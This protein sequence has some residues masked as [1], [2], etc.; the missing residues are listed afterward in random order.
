M[1]AIRKEIKVQ[2]RNKTIPQL[3]IKFL[4]PAKSAKYDLLRAPGLQNTGGGVGVKYARV[5]EASEYHLCQRITDIDEIEP[6]DI[7]FADWLWFVGDKDQSKT[8]KIKSFI[9]LPNVKGIY[10]SECSVLTWE[11]KEVQKLIANAHV[12]THNTEYQ[13]QLYKTLGV[14]HSQFLCDPIPESVFVPAK[15]EQVRRLVCMGQISLAKRSDAVV[16]I[17]KALEGS[18][19][20][21]CY[22]GGKMMWGDYQVMKIE[23][24]LHDEIESV[25][26]RFIENA[27][28]TEVA[29]ITNTSAFYAHVAH[30]DV[31]SSGC[32][33]NM[34]SANVVFGLIH[35]MLKERTPYRFTEPLALAEAIAGYEFGSE[36]HRKDADRVTELAKKWSYEAW[37]KQ[38]NSILRVV[39]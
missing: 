7:V 16:A 29:A 23:S 31:A 19:V 2:L 25:S 34:M 30:H 13:R 17:F 3:I 39:A 10:G 4:V 1:V 38:L 27:T 32:Q 35:P 28:Q 36:Q 6:T 11:G 37:N 14:Y 8:D 9:G 20:E 33:E 22:M 21:R 15:D 26:D 18:G 12:I 24:D 5:E